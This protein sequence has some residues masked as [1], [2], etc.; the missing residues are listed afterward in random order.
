VEFDDEAGRVIKITVPPKF[1][2]ITSVISVPQVN[3]RNDP[4]IPPLRTE[5]GII[6]AT[7]LEYLDTL[8]WLRFWQVGMCV[9]DH[10][11]DLGLGFILLTSEAD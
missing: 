5:L 7:P 11:H 3:L 8:I 6:H 1:G 9:R 2:L 10:F 4:A